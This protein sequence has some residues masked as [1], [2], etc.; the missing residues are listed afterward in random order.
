MIEAYVFLVV[1]VA[2]HVPLPFSRRYR[3]WWKDNIDD[4]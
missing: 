1:F 2:I 4:L 3:Q